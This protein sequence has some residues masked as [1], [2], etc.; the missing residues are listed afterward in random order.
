MMA[1]HAAA[2]AARRRLEMSDAETNRQQQQ[3]LAAV[4]ECHA[5]SHIDFIPVR[6]KWKDGPTADSG[7]SEAGEG[8]ADRG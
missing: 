3:L 8:R 6:S 7:F 2:A 1:W 4:V 5:S